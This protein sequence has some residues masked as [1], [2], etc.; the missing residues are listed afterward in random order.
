MWIAA[1]SLWLIACLGFAFSRFGAGSPVWDAS[2]S[3]GLLLVAPS[4]LVL[5]RM[6]EVPG[7]LQ[8]IARVIRWNS[9]LILTVDQLAGIYT[10]SFEPDPLFDSGVVLALLGMDLSDGAFRRLTSAVKI[11]ADRGLMVPHIGDKSTLVKY[12]AAKAKGF[13]IAGSLIVGSATLA[14]WAIAVGNPEVLPRTSASIEVVFAVGVGG[15]LGRL[16]AW[17]KI[18][19]ALRATK[20]RLDVMPG[21]PDGAAGLAP[22]G[23][24]YLY[25]AWIASL[26]AVFLAG[27]WFLIPLWPGYARWRDLY[28]ALLPVAIMAELLAFL[29]PMIS[30]HRT[31]SDRKAELLARVDA[32]TPRIRLLQDQ[33]IEG[34][35]VAGPEAKQRLADLHEIYHLYTT[36][37]TWPVSRTVRRKFRLTNL[38]LGLPVVGN[39]VGNLVVAWAP[40]LVDRLIH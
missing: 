27:W 38:A 12:M 15:R 7:R 5:P 29:L 16:A 8:T 32:L 35:Q 14:V 6:S 39:L 20:T 24:F 40:Q 23:D 34:D 3:A 2:L 26:P 4:F 17:G 31:M 22:F 36:T 13:R 9:V 33:M 10:R 37:S 1:A 11:V 21:H 18:G 25:Q 28:V 30:I 19:S